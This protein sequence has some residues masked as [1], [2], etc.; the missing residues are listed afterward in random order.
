MPSQEQLGE[1]LKKSHDLLNKSGNGVHINDLKKFFESCKLNVGDDEYQQWQDYYQSMD[2]EYLTFED[3]KQCCDFEE[4][5]EPSGNKT[6]SA[7]LLSG[8]EEQPSEIYST[9]QK[10]YETQLN[11]DDEEDE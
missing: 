5:A 10:P 9:A 3:L 1:S 7:R 4:I 6:P 2:I 11:D 8:I